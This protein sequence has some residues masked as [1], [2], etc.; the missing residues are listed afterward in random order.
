[1]KKKYFVFSDVHGQYDAL[2]Q[3]L[4]EAGY[5]I[6]NPTHILVSCG[7]GFDRGNQSDQ[8]YHLL[9]RRAD[10]ICIKGNHDE[11]LENAIVKGG[12]DT[13]TLFNCL[14]NGLDKTI[15][16]F[17]MHRLSGM[18]TTDYI[19]DC[20]DIIKTR[21][22]KLLSWIRNMPLY[23][24]TDHYVFSHA[25]VDPDL[26]SW[27]DTDPDFM[28]WDIEKSHREIPRS[29]K[30]FIIGHHHAFRVRRTLE[31]LGAKIKPLPAEI[32]AFG[33]TDEHAP[34]RHKNKI[35]IDPCSNYTG[36]VN[37][38][39]F[40]DTDDVHDKPAPES[41]VTAAAYSCKYV[42]IGDNIRAYTTTTGETYTI[43]VGT[44]N[45]WG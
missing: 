10:N 26:M 19:D 17:S 33:N 23:Y 4:M 7:D 38:L 12:K 45:T 22:P 25:G 29:N 20:I 3:S 37:V 21:H 35:A 32:T 36:K 5:D 15:A 40:E 31:S 44:F 8:V 28:L 16:A 2:L 30:Y 41:D 42:N 14:H 39:V 24:E 18:V 6:N 13:L 27:R 34:V 1:M 43:N 11:M 9:S